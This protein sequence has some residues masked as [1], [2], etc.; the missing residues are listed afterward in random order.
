MT[1]KGHLPPG[2]WPGAASPAPAPVPR[3]RRR[4]LT[5]CTCLLIFL[6][7]GPTDLCT[8]RKGDNKARSTRCFSSQTCEEPV[9]LVWLLQPLTRSVLLLSFLRGQ[10]RLRCCITMGMRD[11]NPY[12]SD[13]MSALSTRDVAFLNINSGPPLQAPSCCVCR[14]MCQAPPITY[15][16]PYDN[17]EV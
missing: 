13:P 14:V 11:E 7:S 2:M 12:W 16:R 3:V 8:T 5:D 6:D 10:T 9:T 1:V 4:A 17:H 15:F